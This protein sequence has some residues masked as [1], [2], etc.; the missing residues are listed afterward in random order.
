LGGSGQ[1]ALIARIIEAEKEKKK[2][3]KERKRIG[4]REKKRK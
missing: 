1:R 2:R 4:H 3:K